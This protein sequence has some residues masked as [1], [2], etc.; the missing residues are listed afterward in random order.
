MIDSLF[1]YFNP[2][3]PRGVRRLPVDKLFILHLFQSTH[4]ARGA[5]ELLELPT[6]HEGNFNPRTPRGV[7]PGGAA[8]RRCEHD[9]NP[10][11]PRGVRP[12]GRQGGL[13]MPEFQSTHPARGATHSNS[14]MFLR[15]YYFNPRT[16][17]GVRHLGIIL[18]IIKSTF[19]ST[20]PARGAT[21]GK[22]IKFIM[23]NNFN[24][25]TPRGVRQRLSLAPPAPLLFQS[26]HPA[27]GATVSSVLST[28]SPPISIHAPREGCD[29]EIIGGAQ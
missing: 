22:F 20:H 1:L 11:T 19:Q 16:P 3:T 28:A 26:T 6:Y 27:R 17:R 4:P 8:R 13:S 25:R 14:V 5:T 18:K 2:R 7:R 9:F 10:R 24:P 21:F 15:R 29:D 23:F 12:K